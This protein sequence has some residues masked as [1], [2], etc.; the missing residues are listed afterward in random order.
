MNGFDTSDDKPLD[1][2]AQLQRRNSEKQVLLDHTR[3]N[4]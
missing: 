1:L 3:I 2:E 4:L